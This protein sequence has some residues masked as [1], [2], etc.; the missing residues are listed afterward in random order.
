MLSRKKHYLTTVGIANNKEKIYAQMQ[1]I[2]HVKEQKIT[3]NNK[4]ERKKKK[5]VILVLQWS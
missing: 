2:K 5:D 1:H 3:L 4:K